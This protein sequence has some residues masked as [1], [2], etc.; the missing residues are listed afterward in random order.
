[1]QD[2]VGVGVADA[3]ED[4]GIGEGALERVVPLSK[5][6]DEGG[7]VDR[8]CLREAGVAT[9]DPAA[10]G[11]EGTLKAKLER[12]ERRA[13]REALDSSGGEASLAAEIL[14]V[15]LST[16]YRKMKA[17]GLDQP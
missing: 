10:T 3:R 16:L 1:M 7:L 2:L 17:L 15:H 5:P 11:L 4:P 12:A 8:A 13:I 14:D 6:R 9:A